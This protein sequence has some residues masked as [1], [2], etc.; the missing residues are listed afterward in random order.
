[1]FTVGQR[2][3]DLQSTI[4]ASETVIAG[5]VPKKW[6]HRQQRYLV[7]LSDIYG[8]RKESE[9]MEFQK[10]KGVVYEHIQQI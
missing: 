7:P 3:I 2:V 9:L 10:R 6:W 4:L 5:I 1:M 8:Y